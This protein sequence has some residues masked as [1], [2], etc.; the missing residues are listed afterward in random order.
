LISLTT[1]GLETLRGWIENLT[2]EMGSA[3]A[4]PIRT[5]LNYLAALQPEECD[6]F[7]ARAEQV[8]RLRLD[9]LRNTPIDKAAADS[10]T[11]EATHLGVEMQLEARL[12]WLAKVRRLLETRSGI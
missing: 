5:R 2:D 3:A 9:L 1:T 4:D 12:Q 11:L 7:L 8:T 10:W 6:A